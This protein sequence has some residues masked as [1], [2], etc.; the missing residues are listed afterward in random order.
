MLVHALLHLFLNYSF[1][2]S[3]VK[4]P[5]PPTSTL[6][7]TTSSLEEQ[8][9]TTVSLVRSQSLQDVKSHTSHDVKTDPVRRRPFSFKK[10][11]SF[12]QEEKKGYQSQQGPSSFALKYFGDCSKSAWCASIWTFR[13]YLVTKIHSVL[14]ITTSCHS[15][16]NHLFFCIYISVYSVIFQNNPQ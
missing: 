16:L 12:S 9:V 7:P 10:S 8:P 1:L 5:L 6:S 13:S 11:N 4:P 3:V 14:F 2:S 15:L